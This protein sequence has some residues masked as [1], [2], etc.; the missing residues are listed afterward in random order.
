MKQHFSSQIINVFCFTF[1]NRRIIYTVKN[2]IL[3]HDGMFTNLATANVFFKELSK[4]FSIKQAYQQAINNDCSSMLN[5]S[6]LFNYEERSIRESLIS[7]HNA[8]A[9]PD[10]FSMKITK[11]IYFYISRP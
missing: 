9:E 7:C 1:I 6:Q 10:G 3:L 4:N 2:K 8:A 5:R 11:Q